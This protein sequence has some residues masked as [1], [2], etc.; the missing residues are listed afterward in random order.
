MQELSLAANNL[1]ELPAGIGKLTALKRLQLAGN[2]FES[3]PD[4]IGNCQQLEVRLL[5]WC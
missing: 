5:G 3:L 2:Q 1:A 4:E